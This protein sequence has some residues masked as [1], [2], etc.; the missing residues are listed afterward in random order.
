MKM[1]RTDDHKQLLDILTPARYDDVVSATRSL[2]STDSPQLAK[3]L[4]YYVKQCTMQK[5]AMGVKQENDRMLKEAE[6]F[7]RL[8]ESSWSYLVSRGADRSQKLLTLNKPS[9]IPLTE[10]ILLLKTFIEKEIDCC[11]SNVEQMDIMELKVLVLS[12]LITF[13]KRRP[14]EVAELTFADLDSANG[15]EDNQEILGHLTA[16]E[17]QLAKE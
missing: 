10:D 12:Q 7:N 14:A 13:N 5:I 1:T 16:V 15:E 9:L 17:K 4:G 8:Y 3:C 2:M 6:S 11:L